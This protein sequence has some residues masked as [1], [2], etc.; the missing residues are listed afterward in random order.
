MHN[1]VRG[2]ICTIGEDYLGK[3]RRLRPEVFS[4]DLR[5]RPGTRRGHVGLRQPGVIDSLS[6]GLGVVLSE[7]GRN[8]RAQAGIVTEEQP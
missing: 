3:A 1:E 6:T 7:Y 8:L 4:Q 2:Y 5:S